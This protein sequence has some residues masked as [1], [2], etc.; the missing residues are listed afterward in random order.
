MR[1]TNF[2]NQNKEKWDEFEKI[3]ASDKKDPDKLSNLFI[4]VS[5]D[6][7]YS[8]TFYKNRSVRIYMNNLAQRI[9]SNLYKNKK[10]RS[11]QFG[12]FWKDELP[13]LIWNSRRA[14]LISFV[15]FMLSVIIGVFSCRQ[16]PE[17]PRIILGNAYVEQTLENIQKKD[18]MAIYKDM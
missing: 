11:R 14:F 1:E 16:S 18:P 5:D 17:F 12:N 7:S 4:Q 6:L 2:I 10:T 13:Q 15:V 9:F 8:R 3:L